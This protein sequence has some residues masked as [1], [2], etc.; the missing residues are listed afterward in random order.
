MTGLL[1]C[2]EMICN[3]AVSISKST[4]ILTR[5]SRYPCDLTQLSTGLFALWY[6]NQR[7]Q[8]TKFIEQDYILHIHLV[9][10]E[11]GIIRRCHGKVEAEGLGYQSAPANKNTTVNLL[12]YSISLTRWL[13]ILILCNDGCRLKSTELSKGKQ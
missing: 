9:T 7:C 2:G 6:A 4:G 8:T 5:L 11:V 1:A 13:I 10:V 3:G 12:E